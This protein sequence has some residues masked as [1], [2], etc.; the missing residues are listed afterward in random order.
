MDNKNEPRSASDILS[1]LE[2]KMSVLIKTIAAGN[3][4]NNLILN[5]LN[6][7]VKVQ[8][9]PGVSAEP[10]KLPNAMV[11]PPPMTVDIVKP[12]QNKVEISKEIPILN[13]RDSI[14]AIAKTTK[15]IPVG[16]RIVDANG[17][18]V[19]MADVVITDAGGN[20]FYKGKTNAVGKWQSYLSEG[21]YTVKVSKTIDPNTK[22]KSTTTQTI[23]VGSDA[24]SLKLDDFVIKNGK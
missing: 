20:V 15:K 8:A 3:L 18:D 24:K 5:R 12:A 11:S 23:E 22:E 1:S 16:Q 7:L 10:V 17:K 14:A 2:E 9:G 4:T 13:R 6:Q 21:S 19:F